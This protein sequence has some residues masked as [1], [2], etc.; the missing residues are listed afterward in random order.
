[1]FTADLPT[2]DPCNV[3]STAEHIALA[4]SVMAHN[5]HPLPVVIA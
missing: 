4:E 1:M 3:S 5:Y 2:V